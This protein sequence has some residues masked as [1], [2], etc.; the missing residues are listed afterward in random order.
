MCWGKPPT[1][2][3]RRLG[4][5]MVTKLTNLRGRAR[6]SP[7]LRLSWAPWVVLLFLGW[8][9]SGRRRGSLS[10]DSSA[11]LGGW[12]GAWSRRRSFQHVLHQ[13]DQRRATVRRPCPPVLGRRRHWAKL[14]SLALLTGG[15]FPPALPLVKLLSPLSACVVVGRHGE[16]TWFQTGLKY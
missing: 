6:K 1:P 14:P 9:F 11:L 12:S 15:A 3:A 5:I 16:T 4:H 13:V 8:V 10:L 2:G 7:A